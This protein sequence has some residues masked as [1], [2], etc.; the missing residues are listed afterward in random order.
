MVRAPK[1]PPSP[2]KIRNPN[3]LVVANE[4]ARDAMPRPMKPHSKM[5]AAENRSESRPANKRNEA[6]VMV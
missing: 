2:R 6:K 1:M 4:L 3:L 5:I